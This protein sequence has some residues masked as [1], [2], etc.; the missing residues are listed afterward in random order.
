MTSAG[1]FFIGTSNITLPGPKSSFP[2]EYQN[3]SRLHYYSSL[4]NS[5]E[6]NS[7]FYKIPRSA[8][9]QKWSSE[10]DHEFRF[11]LKLWKE[12]THIKDYAL[13][14]TNID[15]FMAVANSANQNQGCILIQF[16]ASITLSDIDHVEKILLKVRDRNIESTWSLCVE[17]RH[18][19]WYVSKMYNLIDKLNISLVF[20]D[21]P[22]S[23]TPFPNND[24]AQVAYFRFH[25]SAGDYKGSYSE[26]V[27]NQY[28]DLMLELLSSGKDVYVYFNNTL[29]QAFQNAQ[30]LKAK[31]LR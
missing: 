26:S 3:N 1:K 16:P 9:L 10:V 18:V 14:Y 5:L 8:T 27:L 29:G 22:A 17:F 24:N 30:F 4:F 11:S 2:H 12:I 21:M 23:I 19:S 31:L 20:H 28:A 25:G 7:S 13:A 15:K 6:V